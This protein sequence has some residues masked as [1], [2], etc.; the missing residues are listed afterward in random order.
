M[1]L[2][3][4]GTLI[5]YVWGPKIDGKFVRV[6]AQPLIPGHFFLIEELEVFKKIKELLFFQ[7]QLLNC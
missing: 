1:N 3:L 2:F 7:T 6:K 4:S 5:G